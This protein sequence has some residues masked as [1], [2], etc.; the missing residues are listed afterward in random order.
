L[1]DAL[2]RAMVGPPSA[3]VVTT[4]AESERARPEGSA[5]LILI[6]E[7]SPINQQVA[8]GMLEQLGYRADVAGNG[9]EAVSAFGRQPYAAILM[10]CH[11]PEMDG[12]EATIEIRHREHGEGHIPIIA[13]TANAMEGDRDR[14]LA[15]GMDDYLSK[16]VRREVLADMLERWVPASPE[17]TGESRRES[18]GASA[19]ARSPSAG[20]IDALALELLRSSRRPGQPDPVLELIPL[21]L[22]EGAGHLTEIRAGMEHQ[23]ARRVAEAAH[24]LKGDAAVIGAMRVRELAEQIQ[25]AGRADDL[26]AVYGL[27]DQLAA[28]FEAARAALIEI[29]GD[30]PAPS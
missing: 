2:M 26:D 19:A 1:F 30:A 4:V 22:E 14:C 13:M 7:D 25:H 23:D 24:A 18:E 16:P 27:V 5:P 20:V 10:D 17:P 8:R 29:E 9:Q 3:P 15:V 28:S 12:F 6:A 11:M 21:F